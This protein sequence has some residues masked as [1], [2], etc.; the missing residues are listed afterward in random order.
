VPVPFTA[1]KIPGV[2][3]KNHIDVSPVRQLAFRLRFLRQ[4]TQA[5]DLAG[6]FLRGRDGAACRDPIGKKSSK[7]H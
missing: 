1:K 5:R 2:S 7:F 6:F 3:P 4:L